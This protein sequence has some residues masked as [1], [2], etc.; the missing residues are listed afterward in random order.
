MSFLTDKERETLILICQTFVSTVEGDNTIAPA[1]A[2]F[3]SDATRD[4]AEIESL[5]E[6]VT[7]AEEQLS[8]R[9]A[10]QL[11]EQR[12]F[13]TV[14]T[15]TWQGF[16]AMSIAEREEY[17]LGWGQSRFAAS[18][19]LFEVLKILALF[20]AYSDPFDGSSHPVWPDI[21]YRPPEKV[22]PRITSDIRPIE[23]TGDMTLDAEVLVIG[24]GSGGGV[25]ADELSEAGFD[26]LVVEKGEYF[27]EDAFVGNEREGINMMFERRAM[28]A[29]KDG[30]LR[31]L[32]GSTLGGG[33][34][35]NWNTSFATP[36]PILQ[37]WATEFGF[38][39]ALS[40]AYQQSLK[41]VM[42][43]TN[44]NKDYSAA[45][46]NNSV[47]ERGCNALGYDVE[48]LARNVKGCVD[49]SFCDLGCVHGAKQN[50][51]NVFLQT[52]HDRGARVMVRTM[53]KHVLHQNG[54][55]T[56]AEAVSTT[57]DGKQVSVTINAKAVVV[58][59]GSLHTP[60]ILLRSGLTNPNIGQ[61]LHLHPTTTSFGFYE[62]P[63]YPWRGVPQSRA[64]RE[65]SNLDGHHHGIMIETAPSHAGFTIAGLPWRNARQHKQYAS[66]ANKMATLIAITRDKHSGHVEVD[67]NGKPS[68]VYNLHPFDRYHMH[69]GML[70]AAKVHY[71]AGAWRIHT[72]H[73]DTIEYERVGD[74]DGQRFAAFL[75]EISQRPL[76]PL[77]F[78]MYSA[79]QMSSCRVGGSAELGAVDPSGESYDIHNLFVA[80]ASALPSATGVNPMISIMGLAHYISQQIIDKLQS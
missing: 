4:A 78:G 14:V 47:V 23:V 59:A 40:R 17:L 52:A 43:R 38:T 60:A 62:R 5:L 27:K 24:S 6:Q 11:F 26:V 51:L 69:R 63:M 33:T 57:T 66:I 50:A 2:A 29:T 64:S 41:L 32:A 25:V 71:A 58:C 28:V 79:H 7:D 22:A 10:L 15:G 74:H 75:E 73:H 19:R 61:N 44:V 72:N 21:D 49:C 55:V 13:N 34:I 12:A 67:R 65:F 36:Q 20:M 35:I 46:G 48:T 76:K 68:Y 56:G 1:V 39:D 16:S 80:D 42:R 30:A 70:E 53:V 8:F 37:E 54:R 9:R 3:E 45:N 18:R 77:T 31:I